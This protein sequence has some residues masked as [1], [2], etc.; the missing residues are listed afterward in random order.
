[1]GGPPALAAAR[2]RRLTSPDQDAP[3]A[4]RLLRESRSVSSCPW[5][6]FPGRTNGSWSRARGLC[7]LAGYSPY[8]VP[9][10]AAFLPAPEAGELLLHDPY[11]G[12]GGEIAGEPGGPPL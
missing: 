9:R 7:A 1:R 11:Q 3:P 5:F 8:P 10:E 2:G 4:S 12:R 6:I